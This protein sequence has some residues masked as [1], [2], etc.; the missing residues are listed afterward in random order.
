MLYINI[1]RNMYV[2]VLS[3]SMC[4]CCY[5]DE[6]INGANQKLDQNWIDKS[7][8]VAVLDVQVHERRLIVVQKIALEIAKDKTVRV[9][10][11]MKCIN[12]WHKQ[13]H[14]S[15]DNILSLKK[16]V[17]KTN[18]Y[19]RITQW[20]Y[21]QITITFEI[22]YI[23]VKNNAHFILLVFKIHWLYK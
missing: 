1:W 19:Y 4:V 21:S 14:N 23:F 20:V 5:C 10:R 3:K 18:K 15:T 7:D 12:R 13:I 9:C 17:N 6:N 22:Y 2:C 11:K 8:G 16:K